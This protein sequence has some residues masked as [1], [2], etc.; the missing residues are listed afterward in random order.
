MIAVT[1]ND[2]YTEELI[3]LGA[4]YVINTETTLLYNAVMELT[5]GCGAKAAIDSI[6]GR[7]GT[8]LAYCVSP[9]G[10][11]LTI[12]LFVRNTCQLDRNYE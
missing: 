1:R 8:D 6:G 12:G 4:S 7:F 10:T 2:N 11:F 5:N 9:N 3:Q